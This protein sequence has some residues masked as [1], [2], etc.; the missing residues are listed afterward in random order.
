M[1]V[2]DRTTVENA[3]IIV[4]TSPKKDSMLPPSSGENLGGK[5]LKQTQL[6]LQMP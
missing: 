4:S 6:Y 1:V 3:V 5:V 2:K